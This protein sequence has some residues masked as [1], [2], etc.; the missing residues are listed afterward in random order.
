SVA[1]RSYH[2]GQ[3]D[4]SWV[5]SD[6]Q[7][8]V[9]R[10]RRIQS[11]LRDRVGRRHCCYGGRLW[12]FGSRVAP[13]SNEGDDVRYAFLE[14]DRAR[15]VC[16]WRALAVLFGLRTDHRPSAADLRYGFL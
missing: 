3:T 1:G 11:D 7:K 15:L 9:A 14:F 8:A 4:R 5:Y 10:F 12:A 6:R 16:S 2:R 13:L